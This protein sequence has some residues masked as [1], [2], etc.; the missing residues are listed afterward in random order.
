MC[1]LEELFVDKVSQHFI[2][3]IG[4][5]VIE[6]P[7]IT[8]CGHTFCNSCLG[9]WLNTRRQCPTDRLPVTHKQLIPNYLVLNYIADL[10]VKCDHHAQ[11]CQ[12]IG[13]WSALSCHLRQCQAALPK[14]R[15]WLKYHVPFGQQIRVTGNCEQLGNW[16]PKKAFPLKFSQGDTWEGEIILGYQSGRIEYKYFISYFDTGE[17]V[18]WEGGANR[19]VLISGSSI[20]RRDIFR[21][22]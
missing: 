2:C 1:R 14:I 16:D 11:G 13:K 6:D 3:P 17:L 19:V 4:K 7:I 21:N 18:Y 12:W 10:S 8:P 5:G 15:F 22:P 9:G 20:Y